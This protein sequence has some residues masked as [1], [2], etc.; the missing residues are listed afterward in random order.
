[1]AAPTNNNSQTELTQ[2]SLTQ[3]ATGKLNVGVTTKSVGLLK[4][5]PD[6]VKLIGGIAAVILLIVGI[7]GGFQAMSH[8]F[9]AT[10]STGLA[11][12]AGASMWVST[13]ATVAMVGTKFILWMDDEKPKESLP[14]Q[15]ILAKYNGR[16][17]KY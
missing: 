15:A 17:K 16:Q 2:Y 1:M 4:S 5:H 11:V 9:A 14:Y 10:H 6:A 12:A 3:N 13:V 8:T 7:I